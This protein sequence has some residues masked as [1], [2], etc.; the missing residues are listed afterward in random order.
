VSDKAR[1]S[2]F[3]QLH[4]NSFLCERRKK[5]ASPMKLFWKMVFGK[6]KQLI[7]SH[8]TVSE[9]MPNRDNIFNTGKSYKKA[10]RYHLKGPTA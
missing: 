5:T 4:P 7:T 9:A 6:E 3:F 10:E 1:I 8:K 2:Y